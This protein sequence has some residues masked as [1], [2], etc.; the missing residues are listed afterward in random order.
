MLVEVISSN[1]ETNTIL[2]STDVNHLLEGIGKSIISNIFFGISLSIES[3]N[4]NSLLTDGTNGNDD[5]NELHISCLYDVRD[6]PLYDSCARRNDVISLFW[7]FKTSQITGYKLEV[8]GYRL[9]VTGQNSEMTSF[10]LAQ[11]S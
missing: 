7:P 6:V 9:Q 4:T 3:Q 1:R 10:L 8:R 11:L 5:L 2:K